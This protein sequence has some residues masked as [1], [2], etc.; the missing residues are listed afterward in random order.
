[1]LEKNVEKGLVESRKSSCPEI[2]F[3]HMRSAQVPVNEIRDNYP[4]RTLT[5]NVEREYSGLSS[6]MA[7]APIFAKET[8][9]ILDNAAEE[10]STL[11]KKSSSTMN[12]AQ[13]PLS[14]ENRTPKRKENDLDEDTRLLITNPSSVRSAKVHVPDEE[15][16]MIRMRIEKGEGE[17]TQLFTKGEKVGLA[18]KAPLWFPIAVTVSVFVVPVSAFKVLSNK[19]SHQKTESNFREV[20]D[21][22]HLADLLQ[23]L[24]ELDTFSEVRFIEEFERNSIRLFNQWLDQQHQTSIQVIEDISTTLQQLAETEKLESEDKQSVKR[25]LQQ[26]KEC[27]EECYVLLEKCC[28]SLNEGPLS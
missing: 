25:F 16:E 18:L 7:Q 5:E 4:S 1:M 12:S 26:L 27:Q 24:Y 23:E 9:D 19:L 13:V 11:V 8:L 2:S 21:E 15:L 10:N 28:N 22:R 20:T 14:V 17:D 6:I 3:I